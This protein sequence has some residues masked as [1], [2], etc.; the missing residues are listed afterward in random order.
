[1]IVL[2]DEK[3]E[4]KILRVYLSEKRFKVL[5]QLWVNETGATSEEKW[6]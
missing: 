3:K 4:V 1:M 6:M 5:G 2:K